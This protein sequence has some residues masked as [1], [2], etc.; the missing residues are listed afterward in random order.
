[1]RMTKKRKL[2]LKNC[3]ILFISLVAFISLIGN[4]YQDRFYNKALALQDAMMER[5][6]LDSN[7]ADSY[8]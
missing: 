7:V 3:Y 2:N 8:R 5:M 4:F 6:A 1:M